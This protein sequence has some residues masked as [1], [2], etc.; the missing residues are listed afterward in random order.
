MES[1]GGTYALILTLREDLCLQIGRLGTYTFPSGYYIY[2]GSALRGLAPRLKR[3]LRRHKRL[4]WHIDYLLEYGTVV[5]IWY[6]LSSERLECLWSR[7]LG[8]LPGAQRPAPGFG[9]SDCRCPSHLLHFRKLPD[10]GLFQ[11]K[12]TELG[13]AVSRSRVH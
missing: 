13:I 9:S 2:V 4:H 7:L 3:H 10:F 11:E 5:E 6:T 1:G 12:V 8:G